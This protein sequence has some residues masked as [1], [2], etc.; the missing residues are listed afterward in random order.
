MFLTLF[1]SGIFS[2][3]NKKI[4]IHITYVYILPEKKLIIL[5]AACAYIYQYWQ[6]GNYDAPCNEL[7]PEKEQY[8][9]KFK[10][11]ICKKQQLFCHPTSF[12]FY[13]THCTHSAPHL[14]L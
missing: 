9:V 5:T 10:N 13:F 8:L 3:R 4:V 1:C 11:I 14:W 2:K 12:L 6:F 7:V